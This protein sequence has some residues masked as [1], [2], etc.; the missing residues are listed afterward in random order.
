MTFPT[1]IVRRGG[2]TLIELMV[3]V[4]VTAILLGIAVP[5]L[6]DVLLGSRLT[7]HANTLVA[8]LQLARSEAIKRNAVVTVCPSA[9]GTSCTD[10][11]WEQ[12]WIVLVNDTLLQAQ[13]AARHGMRITGTASRIDYQPTGLG[14]TVAS[15]TVC[16]QTPTVGDQERVINTSATGRV[17]VKKTTAGTC[18]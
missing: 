17:S 15:L 12:G 18:S 3:A 11:S 5:S 9:N 4:A 10:G 7:A 8:S 6:L 2:F 14:A 13:G 16:R 1:V